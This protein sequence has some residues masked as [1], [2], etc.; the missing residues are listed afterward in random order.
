MV[1]GRV[2]VDVN[3]INL[4]FCVIFPSQRVRQEQLLGSVNVGSA[5]A[6]FC[7]TFERVTFVEALM[8]NVARIEMFVVQH[9]SQ[10]DPV[11]PC[12]GRGGPGDL[13]EG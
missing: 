8:D 11:W 2:Y 4:C 9:A 7:A 12:R 5:K 1:R 6:H 13:V 3:I 10:V